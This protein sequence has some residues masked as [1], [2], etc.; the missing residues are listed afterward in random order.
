MTI[1][2]DGNCLFRSFAFQL[3]GNQEEHFNVRS[4]LVRFENLNTVHFESRLTSVNEPTIRQHLSKM[5]KP[6]FWGTHIEIIALIASLYQVPVYYC[7]DPP[8]SEKGHMWQAVYP[9]A[10]AS[11]MRYPLVV[12][13]DP[14]LLLNPHTSSLYITWEHTMTVLLTKKQV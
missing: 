10:P 6:A 1:K 9:I 13:D 8:Q 5:S 2:G 11:N 4:L 12:E 7:T 3:L 14:V